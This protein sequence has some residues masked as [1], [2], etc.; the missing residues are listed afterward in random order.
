MWSSDRYACKR[1][2]PVS[3]SLTLHYNQVAHWSRY[4]MDIAIIIKT[5]EKDAC[6]M[7]S[8]IG[9]LEVDAAENHTQ[10]LLWALVQHHA[11]LAFN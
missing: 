8:Y 2:F 10:N 5:E 3:P 7:G 11:F 6:Q 4:I 1:A 9:V